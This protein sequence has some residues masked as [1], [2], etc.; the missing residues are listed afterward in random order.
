M[1]NAAGKSQKG[2]KNLFLGKKDKHAETEQTQEKETAAKDKKADAAAASGYASD[3]Y[4]IEPLEDGNYLKLWENWRTTVMRPEPTFACGGREE[5]LFGD[6]RSLITEGRFVMA[7]IE[8]DCQ[9]VLR[10]IEQLQKLAEGGDERSF[11][12]SCT[13]YRSRNLMVA[14]LF[15]IPPWGKEGKFAEET[16]ENA[17][18]TNGIVYGLD[19]ERLAEIKEKPVY[20]TP[21]PIAYGT[22]VVPGENGKIIEHYPRKLPKQIMVD[23][24]GNAD[25]RIGNF[26]QAI[27]AGQ[28][29][30]DIIAPTSGEAGTTV[31][32]KT[33]DPPPTRPA[34]VPMGSNTAITADG[35]Q[36]VATIS[37]HLEFVGSGF[38]VRAVLAI[39][40]DID[41]N[42][43]NIDMLGDV[44]IR[45]DVREGFSVRASGN[46]IV[47]GVVESANVEAGGDV[48]VVRGIV[49]NNNSL[50][51]AG[52]QVRAKFMENCI[53]YAGQAV[54][55]ECILSSTVYSDGTVEVLNG[56]GIIIGGNLT[57]AQ[58]IK[59]RVIGS[60]FGTATKITLGVLANVQQKLTET[61][62]AMI[63]A[64]KELSE[65]EKTINYLAMDPSPSPE[66]EQK[67]AKAR[68]RK[69]I[70]LM[71]K[72]KN[73][74]TIAELEAMTPDLSMCKVDAKTLHQQ[75]TVTVGRYSWTSETSKDY[76]VLVYDT[77]TNE[78]VQ[79]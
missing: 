28:V 75:T 79:V 14:W 10:L 53:V 62:T 61:K 35:T 39:N 60:E 49:G 54:V 20:F 29:I 9:R 41:L 78:L 13:V 46:I 25:Y 50:T 36:L 59:A 71:Q 37:G 32:G 44:H 69:S 26:V 7:R 57:V 63:A 72:Q 16:I 24:S 4:R 56:R 33:I 21:I 8:Q 55:A 47:E 3:P 42:V 11:D 1:S 5:E 45:G 38:T 48:I 43:G 52:G 64:E 73:S 15:I 65:L 2:I 76:C 6:E 30:C 19:N 58:S 27:N 34:K 18:R 77:K 31:E 23:S 17:L 51:K 74:D 70:L 12:A 40:G 68:L 67:A 66:A 22:P